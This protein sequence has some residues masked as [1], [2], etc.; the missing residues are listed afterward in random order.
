MRIELINYRIGHFFYK[1]KMKS[2]GK[3]FSIL[4]RLIFSSWVPASATIGK[5]VTLGYWGLGIV[6]HSNSVIGDNCLIGQNVTIGRNFGDKKVPVIGNNV[7]IGAGSVIFGE[8]FIGDNVIIGSNS[9]VNKSIPPNTIVAGNPAKVIKKSNVPYWEYDKRKSKL[10][11]ILDLINNIGG[12]YIT[13]RI[14]YLIKIKL[15]FL[16]RKFPINTP[17]KEFISLEKW[18]R[19]N[20]PFFLPD[21]TTSIYK[22][23]DKEHLQHKRDEIVSNTFTYF[24]SMKYNLGPN[25]DW[26]TN[27][28]T[29]YKY[30]INK[31]WSE[32]ED[33]SVEAGDIKY[34]WEKARF[35]FVYYVIRYDYHFNKDSSKFVFGQIEDFIDKN[36]INQGPN[37]KCSQEISLR[38]MNWSFALFFYKESKYLTEELFQKII[39]SIYWQ[40]HHVYHNI[41][42]SRIAVRN[43]H[44]I[45]ET[46]M[47]YLSKYLFPFIPDTEEWSK[48]GKKWLLKEIDYQIYEDGSYLQFSHNY[49]RVVIQ[50]LT[51]VL[52]IN[53]LN[54]IHFDSNLFD[55]FKKTL[56]FLYNHQDD[57]TGWLSNYGNNDG[58]L[59]FPLN[60][61]HYRDF[62]PQLQAFGLLLGFKLYNQL[63]EDSFWYGLDNVGE[64]VEKDSLLNYTIGGF[65]G[66]REKD[67]LTTIRCGAYKDRPSQADA[68]HLDIWYK[69]ENILFDPGTYK[70]NTDE[71]YIKFYNG[72][73]GHNTLSIGQYDQMLRGPRFIWFYWTKHALLK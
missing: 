41:N 22:I 24:S 45:T 63:Y 15:G 56:V 27:P 68:L 53:E 62:R 4:N 58:A 32:I 37:Y 71:K 65:Y 19:L 46:A 9:V 57:Q 67:V 11:I 7:Y 47:L 23:E 52:K 25:Y 44:A 30:D 6:I 36:P 31:H 29:G 39:N 20:I 8:I 59:F 14:I 16:K 35:T 13:F 26:I 61:N 72:T 66:F 70:Y 40:L 17:T 10:F 5:N 48:K 54:N 50:I 55:K 33:F 38:I 60:N 64:K 43:N 34:V 51:W 3:F 42:F 18:K 21:S 12:R 73:K 49:H 2:I 1:R 28:D 69:G